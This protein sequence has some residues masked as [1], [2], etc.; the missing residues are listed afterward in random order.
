MP[1]DEVFFLLDVSLLSVVV[2]LVLLF[3]E[4]VL[5]K[6]MLKGPFISCDGLIL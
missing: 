4:F 3:V 5:L 6:I 2:L 1:C